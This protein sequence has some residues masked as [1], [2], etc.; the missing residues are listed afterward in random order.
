MN[1]HTAGDRQWW[2]IVADQAKHMYYKVM[3]KIMPFG[4]GIWTAD[5]RW[6][7]MFVRKR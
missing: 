3:P 2:P 7:K 4:D 5:G 6:W 1:E